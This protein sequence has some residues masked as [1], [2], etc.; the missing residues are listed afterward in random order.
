VHVAPACVGSRKGSNRF[1]SYVCNISL[2]FCK[3]LFPRLK[4]M[5]SWSQANT[6]ALPFNY[7]KV[8]RPGK[9]KR[10]VKY[11]RDFAKYCKMLQCTCAT[12]SCMLCLVSSR[13]P[14]SPA[15]VS[16][17]A[18]STDRIITIFDAAGVSGFSALDTGAR[19]ACCWEICS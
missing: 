17:I 10:R 16:V 6:T 13:L 12:N 2:H 19:A 1:G 18:V 14:F 15:S 4:P 5:T 7:E 3:R 11:Y 8:T 9:I